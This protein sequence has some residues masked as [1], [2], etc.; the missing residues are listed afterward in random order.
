MYGNSEA[1]SYDYEAN[2]EYDSDEELFM[3]DHNNEDGAGNMPIGMFGNIDDN[4]RNF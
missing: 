2:Q 4:D 1:E 3:A